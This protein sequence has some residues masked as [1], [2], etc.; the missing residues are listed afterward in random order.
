[1][2]SIVTKADIESGLRDLGVKPGMALEVHSALHT[3]GYVEG[4]AVTLI[5]ALK[6]T[7]GSDGAIVMPS[8]RFS[9]FL[10]LS[11]QDRELGLTVKIKILQGDEERSGMGIV[12]DTFR[13]MPDVK[14]GDGIFRVSAWGKDVNLHAQSF[15]HLI[16]I[17]GWA[18][19]MGVDIH[20][21][22]TMHYVEGNLP[23]AVKDRFKPPE[24]ARKLY[25]E[26]EWFIEAWTPPVKPWYTIQNRAY[27]KGFIRDGMIGES[28]CMFLK[29][30]D[31]IGLYREALQTD[32]LGL[33]G[34]RQVM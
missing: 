27:E 7:V 32:P 1:M 24:E 5:E 28:K 33:Y 30:K 20:R 19:L 10:P 21:L 18:L 4:G 31:V 9:H 13:K 25:P 26:N 22:S 23:E 17:G 3:F 12:P 2:A 16:D 14:T 8:F 11:E 6:Q 29:V 34:L 15:Q